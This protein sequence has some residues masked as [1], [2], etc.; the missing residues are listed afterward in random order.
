MQSA[1]VIT[2]LDFIAMAALFVIPAA[3]PAS[4][5]ARRRPPAPAPAPATGGGGAGG[6]EEA[7]RPGDSRAALGACLGVVSNLFG[8]HYSPRWTAPGQHGL[9]GGSGPL[10][11]QVS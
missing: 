3:L 5:L 1:L 10:S 6:G 2:I 11:A 9:A 7:L 4:S 8:I